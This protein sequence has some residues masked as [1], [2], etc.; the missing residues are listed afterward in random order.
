MPETT[1]RT[2]RGLV[3]LVVDRQEDGEGSLSWTFANEASAMSVTRAFRQSKRWVLVRGAYATATH[4]LDAAQKS[5]LI[6]HESRSSVELRKCDPAAT[7]KERSS[8]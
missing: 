1:D 2:H 7:E 3:T 8:A 6:I 5:E 4:A